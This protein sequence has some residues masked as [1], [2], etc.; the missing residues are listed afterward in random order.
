[1]TAVRAATLADAPSI[2]ALHAGSWRRHYRG[3]FADEY[4]DGPVEADRLRVWSERLADPAPGDRTFVACSPSDELV[5][6]AHLVLDA[7]P[8]LGALLDNL[9]VVD[10]LR[11]GGVGTVLLDR[12]LAAAAGGAGLFLWVLAGNTSAQAFYSARGGT[13]GETVSLPTPDGGTTPAVR[14]RWS[15]T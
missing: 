11:G 3:A 12:V 7:D 5:G 14:Y 9:H 4:L 6:F 1:V 8:A 2:A 10:H 15:P 13:P